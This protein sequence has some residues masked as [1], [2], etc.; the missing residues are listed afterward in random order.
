MPRIELQEG[1]HY[2]LEN[3]LY[4]F[5]GRFLLERGYCCGSK[6]R[7]CPYP[8]EIQSEATARR[9]AGKPFTREEFA[10]QFADTSPKQEG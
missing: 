3:D 8:K 2:Y 7:H 6:C 4:V 1:L 9:L 10:V 5:T